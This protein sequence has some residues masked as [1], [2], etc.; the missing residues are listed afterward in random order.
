MWKTDLKKHLGLQAYTEWNRVQQSCPSFLSKVALARSINYEVNQVRE[1]PSNHQVLCWLLDH[2]N[3]K[4]RFV[5]VDDFP[6]VCSHC[7]RYFT[8]H[9]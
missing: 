3:M 8:R 2:E 6:V 5:P 9:I 1:Q 7:G 4:Y